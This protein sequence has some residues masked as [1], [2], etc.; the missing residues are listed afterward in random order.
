MDLARRLVEREK[1]PIFIVNGAVG[2][3]RIDQHQRN[4]AN[5]DDLSTI[6]GKILLRVKQAKLTHGIRGVLWHQGENNQGSAWVSD[7]RMTS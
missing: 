1:M 3:T 2:G 4:E 5:H 6:Y 7:F